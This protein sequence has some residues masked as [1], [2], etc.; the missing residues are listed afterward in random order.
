M[1]FRRACCAA[2]CAALLEAI[3]K[4]D[5]NTPA[6]AR[7]AARLNLVLGA[8]TKE[9]RCVWAILIRSLDGAHGHSSPAWRVRT[10]EGAHVR[11]DGLQQPD[12]HLQKRIGLRA[13]I[14]QDHANVTERL[15]ND[16]INSVLTPIPKQVEGLNRLNPR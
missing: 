14:P 7:R 2:R 12:V 1:A 4:I 8:A 15:A 6:S 13:F 10:C 5:L 3:Y 16:S 9:S 11:K